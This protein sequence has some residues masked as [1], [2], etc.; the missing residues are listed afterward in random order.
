[1]PLLKN[2]LA[3]VMLEMGKQFC[4]VCGDDFMTESLIKVLSLQVTTRSKIKLI[5]DNHELFENDEF[6]QRFE[7]FI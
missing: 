4:Y 2:K 1:M 7:S 5:I 3:T 6:F